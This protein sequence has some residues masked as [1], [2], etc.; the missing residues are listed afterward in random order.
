MALIP[1]DEL[2]RQV[3]ITSTITDHYWLCRSKCAIFMDCTAHKTICLSFHTFQCTW[4]LFVR[5][6]KANHFQSNE[7]STL[8]CCCYSVGEN[9]TFTC[10]VYSQIC[11]NIHEMIAYL[12]R[13]SWRGGTIVQASPSSFPH[14]TEVWSQENS[15]GRTKCESFIFDFIINPLKKIWFCYNTHFP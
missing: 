5:H 4:S 12:I 2:F 10:T 14:A 8:F 11:I 15:P 6:L 13:L 7:S 1:K 3:C 9:H